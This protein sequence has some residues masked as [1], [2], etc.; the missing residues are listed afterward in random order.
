VSAVY[1][2]GKIGWSNT[3]G[4]NT[5][6]R[7]AFFSQDDVETMSGMPRNSLREGEM[8]ILQ[9]QWLFFERW[10]RVHFQIREDKILY[11]NPS[12]SGV[13]DLWAVQNL[14]NADDSI[15]MLEMQMKS[16]TQ[17]FYFDSEVETKKWYKIITDTILNSYALGFGDYD[18]SET[19]S[20]KT[21]ISSDSREKL[22]QR[23]RG[24][25]MALYLLKKNYCTNL[26][27]IR[28]LQE[29]IASA[30]TSH[31]NKACH[32]KELKFVKST[33]PSKSF[34]SVFIGVDTDIV[35][36]IVSFL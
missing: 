16:G 23:R 1:V 17:Y 13:I 15:T 30:E 7:I 31:I 22:W 25:L 3:E 34:K 32:E 33:L 27:R 36:Y 10:E 11:R 2:W 19:M 9:Y 24:F 28:S 35:K 18:P 4:R 21:T 20:P 26:D 29:L 14:K 12:I 8:T 5:Y 6:G